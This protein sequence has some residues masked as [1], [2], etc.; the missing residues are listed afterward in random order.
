MDSCT[1]HLL[2]Q[3]ARATQFRRPPL[4][5]SVNFKQ[6]MFEFNHLRSDAIFIF[7]MEVHKSGYY[8]LVVVKHLGLFWNDA[9]VEGSC[10]K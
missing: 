8:R 7:Y 2:A 9:V 5:Q 10:P 1:D 6:W 4:G 3:Y